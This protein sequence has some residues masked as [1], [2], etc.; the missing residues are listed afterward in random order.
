[1]QQ[2]MQQMQQMQKGQGGGGQGPGWGSSPGGNPYGPENQSY[3]HQSYAAQDIQQ[4][5]GRV[6]AS[7]TENGEVAPGEATVQFNASRTEAVQAAE[8]AVTEDRVPRRYHESVKDY[9]QQLPE[10]PNAGKAPA[11]PR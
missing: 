1:M 5:E 4:G 6:I 9:F 2:A 10:D 3:Q 7:W 11:A 8:R